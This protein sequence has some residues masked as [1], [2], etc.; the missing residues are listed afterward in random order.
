[1]KSIWTLAIAGLTV[2]LIGAVALSPLASSS[3]DGLERVAEDQDFADR[4][5]P[6]PVAVPMPDYSA[7]GPDSDALSTALA[8]AAGTIVAF[9][10]G[11]GAAWA[12]RRRGGA[13]G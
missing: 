10:A 5:R 2:A 1:M 7:P 6:H 4:A 12:V 13:A 9:G 11:L 3:P 8:G